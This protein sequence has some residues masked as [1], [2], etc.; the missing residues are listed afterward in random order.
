MFPP[1]LI[2]TR[3][4]WLNYPLGL[5]FR[6]TNASYRSR[7]FRTYH[8]CRNPMTADQWC[9]F[10]VSMTLGCIQKMYVDVVLYG[11]L[12]L[13]CLSVF[14][15]RPSDLCMIECAKPHFVPLTR[16]PPRTTWQN[17]ITAICSHQERWTCVSWPTRWFVVAAH[18]MN[19]APRETGCRWCL[20]READSGWNGSAGEL[21]TAAYIHIEE[22]MANLW[23]LRPKN[24]TSHSEHN[25]F[26]QLHTLFK[27]STSRRRHPP[28]F[29]AWSS[30]Y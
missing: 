25:R 7:R 21:Q 14:C 20:S 27:T 30:L 28:K 5:V 10:E 12:Y 6:N 3:S 24:A 15:D 11:N 23:P 4:P 2:V 19:V 13:R 26:V 22:D 29:L 18:Y 1:L 9:F 17:N 8:G 16:L